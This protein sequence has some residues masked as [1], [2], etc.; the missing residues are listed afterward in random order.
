[1]SVSCKQQKQPVT[2]LYSSGQVEL[3]H[4]NVKQLVD[5]A[6]SKGDL[7]IYSV[8]TFD[9]KGNIIKF[10]NIHQDGIDTITY[11]TIYKKGKKVASII[12]PIE[13]KREGKIYRY[14]N[15]GHIISSTSFTNIKEANDSSHDI[16][17]FWYDKTGHLVEE[18]NFGWRDKLRYLYDE[19]GVLTGLERTYSDELGRYT[20]SKKDTIRYI[21]FD[22]KNNWLKA[23]A[24]GDTT[25]RKITYY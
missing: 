20:Y 10:E 13:D 18:R 11:E 2:W 15:Y 19:K 12:S 25:T 7:P 24:Y 1:M 9:K 22:S 16:Y 8:Y 21:L 14:D 5:S 4:G 3:L 6:L 17:Q 23:V